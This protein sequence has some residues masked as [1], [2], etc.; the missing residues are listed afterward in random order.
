MG[1]KPVSNRL[2]IAV[3]FIAPAKINYRK[4]IA[5]TNLLD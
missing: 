3:F 5:E 1:P 2:V 4:K